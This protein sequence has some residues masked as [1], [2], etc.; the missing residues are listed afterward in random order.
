[1]KMS[2]K[3]KKQQRESK[4]Y[5]GSKLTYYKTIKVPLKKIFRWNGHINSKFDEIIFRMDKLA[6]QGYEFIR[7]FYIFCVENQF[8]PATG[9][10]GFRIINSDE[11]YMYDISKKGKKKNIF[12]LS[13]NRSTYS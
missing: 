3:R 4:L 12:N 2:R 8:D 9:D 6:S 5:D 13:S 11:M 7:L 10:R 1:M